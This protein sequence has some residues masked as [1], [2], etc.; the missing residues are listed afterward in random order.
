MD[1][2]LNQEL[3]LLFL[4]HTFD[5]I[6]HVLVLSPPVSQSELFRSSAIQRSY[7]LPPLKQHC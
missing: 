2:H 3:L 6:V 7:Y 5:I 1:E 4:C